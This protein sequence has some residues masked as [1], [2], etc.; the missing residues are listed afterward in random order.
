MEEAVGKYTMSV[1]V[2]LTGVEAHRIRRYER[3]GLLKPVRTGGG[4][5]LYSDA[6]LERIKEISGLEEKGVNLKGIGMI[7][8]MR[9][10]SEGKNPRD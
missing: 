7:L 1:A 4:Q 10:E 9:H 3:M 8:A 5:R 2:Q 6:E